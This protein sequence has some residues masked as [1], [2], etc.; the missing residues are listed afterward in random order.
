MSP[1]QERIR[2]ISP[3]DDLCCGQRK[4]EQQEEPSFDAH[5]AGRAGVEIIGT[6]LAAAKDGCKVGLVYDTNMESHVKETKSHEEKE[7]ERPQRTQY[8]F[9]E[10]AVRDTAQ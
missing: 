2:S 4:S 8:I 1:D 9:D 7:P 5:P 10:L 3:D 6:N